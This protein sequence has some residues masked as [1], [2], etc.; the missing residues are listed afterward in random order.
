M[1]GIS[2]LKFWARIT[3]MSLTSPWQIESDDP[4]SKTTKDLEFYKTQD[5]QQF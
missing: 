3:A 5:L 2:S 1:L 4:R